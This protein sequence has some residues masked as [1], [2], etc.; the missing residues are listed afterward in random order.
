LVLANHARSQR[1]RDALTLVFTD[2]ANRVHSEAADVDHEVLHAIAALR[3][4]DREALILVGW[5]GLRPA[6][7]A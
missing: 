2:Q 3:A 4:D 5:D 7:A 1:R 6:E